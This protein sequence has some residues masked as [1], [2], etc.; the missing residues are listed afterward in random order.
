MFDFLQ[1]FTCN[2]KLFG[3]CYLGLFDES[4]QYDH[5]SLNNA[6]KQRSTNCFSALGAHLEKPIT[7]GARIWQTQ[8]WTR[9]LHLLR[10][11]NKISVDPRWPS[12]YG[13]PNFGIKE[14]KLLAYID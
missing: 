10:N 4:M 6:T 9:D 3:W 7:K 13:R 5:M 14:L 12:H 11:A 2:F 8:V 1:T